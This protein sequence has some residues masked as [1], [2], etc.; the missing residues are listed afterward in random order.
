MSICTIGKREAAN[1]PFIFFLVGTSSFELLTPSVSRK[2]S[3]PELRAYIC[4]AVGLFTRSQAVRQV[5][6]AEFSHAAE[7]YPFYT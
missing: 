7:I 1:L 3:T 5:F 4:E 6:A 2:C